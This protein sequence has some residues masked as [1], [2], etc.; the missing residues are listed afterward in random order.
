MSLFQGVS[1][2]DITNSVTSFDVFQACFILKNSYRSFPKGSI[3]LI[4]VGGGNILDKELVAVKANGHYFVGENDGRFSLLL[5]DVMASGADVEA[6]VVECKH[7][8][9]PMAEADYY[10]RGIASILNEDELPPANLVKS[11]ADRAVVMVDKIIGRVVYIDSY[12]NAI[13]NISQRDFMKVYGL[14]MES[15]CTD[16]EQMPDFVVYVG[17]PHLKFDEISDG[18]HSVSPADEVAF[19]NSLGL[20]ELAV[21][22]GNFASLEG[23]DTTTEVMVK[24][25]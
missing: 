2:V 23:V 3:H 21:N 4:T 24:F 1:V 25:G 7:R 18:Y 6:G 15:G 17:G 9:G 8:M 22:R 11:G 13:T 14:I 16:E 20:L 19:F 12:G 5:D 10:C